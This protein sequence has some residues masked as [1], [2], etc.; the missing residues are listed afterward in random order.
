MNKKN[1]IIFLMVFIIKPSFSATINEESIKNCGNS[2]LFLLDYYSKGEKIEFEDFKINRDNAHALIEIEKSKDNGKEKSKYK[3]EYLKRLSPYFTF[4]GIAGAALIIFITTI[5]CWSTPS[6]CYK[7]NDERI[8]IILFFI[9][10]IF[11]LGVFASC[12]SG[13]VFAERFK[14]YLNGCSCSFERLFYNIYEGQ[15]KFSS[16]KWNGFDGIITKLK[17][18]KQ[19]KSIFKEREQYSFYRNETFQYENLIDQLKKIPK[20]RINGYYFLN[21][22]SLKN[23]FEDLKTEIHTKID[24]YVENNNNTIELI[25]NLSNPDTTLINNAIIQVESLKKNFENFNQT[26]LKDYESYKKGMKI[27]VYFLYQ[28]FYSIVFII[29][30]FSILIFTIYFLG[31]NNQKIYLIS[32]ILWYVIFIISII[33]FV[34]GS[35]YGMISFAIH[36]SIGYLMYIFGEE[37]TNLEN[38]IIIS[39]YKSFINICVQGN[40][41]YSLSKEYNLDSKNFTKYNEIYKNIIKEYNSIPDLQ[42][43]SFQV[44][45]IIETL[46]KNLLEYKDITSS[47]NFT[48]NNDYFRK[49]N[50]VNKLEDCESIQKDKTCCV[51]SNFPYDNGDCLEYDDNVEEGYDLYSQNL[52][53][54][55]KVSDK[56]NE[57]QSEFLNFI[58]NIMIKKIKLLYLKFF[59][60]YEFTENDVISNDDIFLF[61]KCD[62]V[63]NDLIAVYSS[64][65]ELA[66]YVRILCALT[67]CIAFF[68]LISGICIQISMLNSIDKENLNDDSYK[69]DDEEQERIS[70]KPKKIES[71]IINKSKEEN[72]NNQ[73]SRI[74][75]LQEFL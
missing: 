42:K 18:L 21:Y 63:N 50:W 39:S 10:I 33:S 31:I 72:N 66:Y 9:S 15:L 20:D 61:M 60:F 75:E 38:P 40:K 62:F 34:L 4:I 17:E 26:I 6:C 47:F 11:L 64:L 22:E 16:P 24:D 3:K 7:D 49:V 44:L 51:I 23:F 13:F 29:I 46:K 53:I 57:I 59:N 54:I 36:D 73:I 52:E 14:F 71:E 19:L 1:F 25:K 69:D 67:L 32:K 70:E 41:D 65:Y 74:S 35:V 30:I 28:T 12:I 48:I 58:N 68:T 2:P 27:L 45:K 56:I 55:D 37:N 5:F 8:R 43:P